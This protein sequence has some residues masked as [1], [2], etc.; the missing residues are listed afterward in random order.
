MDGAT[1]V[2]NQRVITVAFRDFALEIALA[3]GFIVNQVIFIINDAVPVDIDIDGGALDRAVI[4][5]AADRCAL[6]AGVSGGG[7]G[8]T[9]LSVAGVA[10]GGDG[11]A[12]LSVAGVAGGGDGDAALS[13]AG[14]F[15]V[16]VF[17]ADALTTGGPPPPPPPPQAARSR[18][19]G[20]DPPEYVA[21][22]ADIS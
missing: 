10:G 13:V 16:D 12:A 22:R 17:W 14:V 9:A 18:T 6:W 19:S 21:P 15:W 1:I 3:V 11:D 7:D 2:G 20:K 5:A 4:E 8:D